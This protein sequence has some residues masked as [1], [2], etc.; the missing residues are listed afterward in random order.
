MT[1]IAIIG[2]GMMGTALCWPLNDNHHD[3]R[4]VGTHLDKDIIDSLRATGY[5]PRLERHIPEEVKSFYRE[6]LEGAVQGAE[7]VV[8][9]VSSFGIP[10]FIE[11]VGPYLKPEVPVLAVTKGLV[12]LPDG[13]LQ[14]L[15]EYIN[16]H[17]PERLRGRIS[18][19]AIG[20]PCTALE[21][22]ARRKTCVVFCGEDPATLEILKKLFA[23]PYYHV[24]TSTDVIGVETCAALKNAY[25]LAVGIIVGMMEQAGPD[26][27]AWMYNPQAAVFSQS[28]REMRR[29]LEISG[30][31]VENVSWLPGVGDLY[32]TIYGG[33]TRM[34]GKMLGQGVS[35]PEARGRL[36]GVTLES[37][38]IITR[39]G[40]ALSKLKQR[41]L[42]KP[43]ELPLI[44]HLYRVIHEG[45]PVNLPW[46][47]FFR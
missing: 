35:Y 9:G 32:V 15:P 1:S 29:F 5:H 6:Q 20:G 10:W 3:V 24:W 44:E 47:L 11:E 31:G 27:L 12:D 30:G 8:N 26:G 33:R 23:G 19:N 14:V 22:A 2:A 28:C 41:G 46:E 21:L 37:V 17:L 39:V 25:A 42:V 13:S 45:E 40:R 4:L 36:A 7:V 43:N 38:E 18:L 34:L 16:A